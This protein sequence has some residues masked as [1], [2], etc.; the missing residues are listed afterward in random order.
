MFFD[1]RQPT[2]W[3]PHFNTVQ[4]TFGRKMSRQKYAFSIPSQQFPNWPFRFR[5]HHLMGSTA[6]TL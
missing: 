4:T 2:W 5:F 6:A 3:V 1:S